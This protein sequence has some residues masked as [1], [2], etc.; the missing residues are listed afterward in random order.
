M[1]WIKTK[2]RDAPPSIIKMCYVCEH[3]THFVYN[4]RLGHSEC[5][6]CGS[7]NINYNVKL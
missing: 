3:K 5:S 2:K 4:K 7:R 6:E 1:S